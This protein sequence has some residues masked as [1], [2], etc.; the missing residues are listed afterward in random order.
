MLPVTQCI[1][2]PARRYQVPPLSF[3]RAVHECSLI[4]PTLIK[5]QSFICL[6]TLEQLEQLLQVLAT[7][8]P[9]EIQERQY[10]Q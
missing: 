9:P 7:V 3:Q 1:A 5:C 2:F 4:I 8:L 10:W 6:C